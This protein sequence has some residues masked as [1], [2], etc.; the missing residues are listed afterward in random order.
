MLI[1]PA[2]DLD[3]AHN[4]GAQRRAVRNERPGKQNRILQKNI[5]LDGAHSAH[6]RSTFDPALWRD[7]CG[8]FDLDRPMSVA[9]VLGGPTF[10]RDDLVYLEVFRSRT[11]VEP[12]IL[13]QSH[14][15]NPSPDLSHSTMI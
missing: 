15:S 4:T 3:A 8:T 9:D 5:S 14:A 6:I 10:V 7:L 13:L 2:Y 12:T 11:N 1:G